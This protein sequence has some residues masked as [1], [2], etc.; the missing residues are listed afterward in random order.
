MILTLVDSGFEKKHLGNIGDIV[1]SAPY[2]VC[3]AWY[4]DFEAL[5]TARAQP[6]CNALRPDG[7]QT[8]A[9]R[10]VSQEAQMRRRLFTRAPRAP[11]A[12]ARNSRRNVGHS[13]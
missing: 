4:V 6:I 9:D 3:T 8:A 7:V 12:A 13:K 5:A 1:S 11:D 2:S 10:L